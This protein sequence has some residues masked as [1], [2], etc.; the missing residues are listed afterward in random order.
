MIEMID[1]ERTTGEV[2][3]VGVWMD[4]KEDEGG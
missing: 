3:R 2:G 4:G 1:N